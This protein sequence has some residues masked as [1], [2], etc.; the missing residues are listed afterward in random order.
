MLDWLSEPTDGR[1]IRFALDGEGWEEWSYARL[2]DATYSV[3]ERLVGAGARHN[4]VV[5]LVIP[6]G[7][8]FVAAYFGALVAGATPAPLVP[9]TFFESEQEYVGRTAEL[10]GAG[11][12]LVA[13]E[14][15]LLP[16]VRE[17]AV[18]AR[19]TMGVVGISLDEDTKAEGRRP[20]AELALLQ[21]TSGSSGR[22]RGVKV[23]Y[24]NLQ[25]NIQMIRD[26]IDWG[27][28]DA[29]AHWL[30]LYHDMGLIGCLLTPVINQ[31]DLWIMRPEHFIADPMR[32]LDC[33]GRRGASFTA[34]PTFG[35]SYAVSKI[36][37]QRLN[38]SD[39]SGWRGAIIGAERLDPGVLSRFA[40]MLEGY[41][42]R[43]DVFLPAYGLAEAT[44]A[45]TML[46]RGT[47]ARAVRPDWP[48][49]TFAA[50]VP[51]ADCATVGDAAIG[52][53]AGWLTG[54][55]EAL[56]DVTVSIH[57]EAGRE[58]PQAHVGEVRL[59]G[60]IVAR[61]YI[62]EESSLT[63]FDTDSLVTG[64]AG[65]IYDG[66]LYVIGRLGDAVKVR[67]KTLYAEDMEG[68]LSALPDVPTG[69]CVVLPGTN[70][71]A[72][73]VAIVEHVNGPWVAEAAKVLRREA[74]T[75]AHIEILSAGRG[76]IMRTSSG[77]PRRR[78]MW[79]ALLDGTVAATSV[80][81]SSTAMGTI[82]VASDVAR[83]SARYE[84]GD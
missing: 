5:A 41:G 20:R 3:A 7:P 6:T 65:F 36:D 72:G 68:K 51:I 75:G 1:G 70:D 78:V 52:D 76:T 58:L 69:R 77:K 10:L 67:G 73:M 9:P 49:L 80:Y 61:G 45:V 32:W 4:D 22:P 37:R 47:V 13:T 57:D 82:G 14:E 19:S 8:A 56:P 63:K 2:A 81:D 48:T 29:G 27:P 34:G 59:S 83:V 15:S 38:G 50:P 33:F 28:D 46:R 18:R 26:W 74:G 40:A 64:D 60:P 17:A 66:D 84:A 44:L 35:F 30:P 39:F 24:D 53:G 11:V 54:C 31:R 12:Q 43:R 55:G 42:F 23:G 16:L 21:F 71:Q 79:R 25:A 62:G